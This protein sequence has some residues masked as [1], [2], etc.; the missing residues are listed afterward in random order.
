[1][2]VYLYANVYIYICICICVCIR[3]C[4]LM[5][6]I[7]QMYIRDTYIYIYIHII[8]DDPIF[9]VGKTWE[10]SKRLNKNIHNNTKQIKGCVSHQNYLIWVN[11]LVGGEKKTCSKPPTSNDF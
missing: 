4:A 2:Y 8:F 9:D 1:M 11:N 5:L 7:K 6:M 10:N 3:I